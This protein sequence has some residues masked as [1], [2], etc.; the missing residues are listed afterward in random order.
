M[1]LFILYQ[2]ILLYSPSYLT[3]LCALQKLLNPSPPEVTP[4]PLTTRLRARNIQGKG[5]LANNDW[6][7]FI[8][9]YTF[10][11]I[12]HAY[13][14]VSSAATTNNTSNTT[15]NSSNTDNNTN[16]NITTVVPDP[17]SICVDEKLYRLITNIIN[18]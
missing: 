2:Q 10:N 7:C 15:S 11:N 1:A 17:Y 13:N 5:I 8:Y 12:T 16:T 9:Y 18:K 4:D 3:R 14:I 6:D